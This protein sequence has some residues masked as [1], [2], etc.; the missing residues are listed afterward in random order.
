M[1]FFKLAQRGRNKKNHCAE[2][3]TVTCSVHIHNAS[4]AHR[5]SIKYSLVIAACVVKAGIVNRIAK[6]VPGITDTGSNK[7]LK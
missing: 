6:G 2:P 7:L 3:E 5:L 4:N 1:T